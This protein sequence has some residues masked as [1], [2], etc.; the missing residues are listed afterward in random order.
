MRVSRPILC[1][2]TDAP[3]QG[4][5][6]HRARQWTAA[7]GSIA[8]L[9]AGGPGPASA[10]DDAVARQLLQRGDAAA[11]LALID[12]AAQQPGAGLRLRFLRAVALMELRQD[13]AA[14]QAFSTLAQEHPQLPEPYNNIAALHARAG[15]WEQARQALETALRNDPGHLVARENLGDVH[16]QLAL[17]AWREA[18]APQAAPGEPALNRKIRIVTALT[19]LAPALARTEAAPSGTLHGVAGAVPPG[20]GRP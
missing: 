10:A 15:R 4:R 7:F 17:Q 9:W 18:R 3:R 12:V 6:I 2:P 13:A 8:A 14:L 19:E 11:A 1:L 16:L 20:A 5:R